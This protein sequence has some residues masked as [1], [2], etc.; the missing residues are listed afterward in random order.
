[1]IT[2]KIYN[3]M[4]L[5]VLYL[6]VSLI[7]HAQTQNI[8]GKVF[9]DTGETV[10]GATVKVEGTSTATITN[11]DGTFTLKAAIGDKLVISYVGYETKTV[12]IVDNNLLQIQIVP[13]QSLLDEVVVVGYGQQKKAS[14]V[15]A[16]SI[17]STKELKQSPTANITNALAGKLPGL[18]TVQTS[19]EP[20]A[21][22]A[23]LY[24]RGISTFSGSQNPLIL[25]DGVERDFKNMNALEIETISILKDA[26][27]TAVYGVRG[28]NGVVL[29]TTKRGQSGKPT[30]SFNTDI[31][32]QSA[33][34]L[35][36]MVNAYEIATLI[37]EGYINEGY[38]PIYSQEELDAYKYGT[39]PYNYPN[40]NWMDFMLK[41]RTPLQQYN[42]S[43]SG[44]T[45]KAKY[46]VM[47]GILNQGGLYNFEDYNKDYNT[48]VSYERYNFRT[49]A[50]FQIN[51][52]LSTKVNLSGVLGTKHQ[53]QWDAT[54]AFDRFKISN[55]HRAP[56]KN[57]DGSWSTEEKT[58][59]NP[60]AMLLD[61]GYGDS[62]ETA[63]TATIG[64][65]ATLDEYVKGLGA[66][67][68]FSFDFNNIYIQ[69]RTRSVSFWDFNPRDGSYSEIFYGSKLGY[70][71]N[72]SVYNTRYN[73]EPSITY[74]N[75]F[76]EIHE[77]TGLLLYNQ[78][79]Y[80][81]K[82][83]V[84]LERLPY[85]RMGLVGRITYGYKNKYLAEFNAGYNGSEN[86]APGKR[87]GFFP[88]GSLGWVAS[89][90]GFFKKDF[91]EYLKLRMSVGLVGNDQIGGDRYLYMSLYKDDTGAYFGYPSR[92]R[93]AGLSELRLGNPE[94]TW[95][96]ATK[97][98]LGIDTRIF[99]DKL[100]LTL[101]AFY[102]RRKDILTT[103]STIPGTFGFNNLVSNDGVVSNHGFEIDGMWRSR[104]GK[105]FYFNVGG[106]FSF[107]RNK[108]ESMP[109]SPQQYDYLLRTGTR[110]GQPFGKIGLGLF[111]SNE[112]ILK[113][114]SQPA[115]VQPGDIKYMDIN[116][117][118]VVNANDDHPIGNP[119]VPEIFFS[120]TLGFSF[121]SFDFVC[122]FQG[123]GNSTY[124]FASAQ[125]VP[126][127]NENNTPLKVWMGRWTPENRNAIY[128][129]I[130]P[131]NNE[132]NSLYSSF[133]Q[134]DNTYLRLKNM[135]LGYTFNKKFI[136]K[137]GL[138]NLRL[139]VNSVNLFTWD[140][141]KVYDPENYV[142]GNRT[143]YPVMRII[144][145]GLN[146]TF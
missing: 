70:G 11:V 112:E 53:P 10:I 135:E 6:M 79:E 99:G 9:D 121:K 13:S 37:N 81:K 117:D 43:I 33:T 26:S 71:E 38:N 45:A 49:N 106:T 63:I 132:N 48:Q 144:N 68:D 97:Y 14:V 58:S 102:E 72:L 57:P 50:D 124:Y 130:T 36:E 141:V 94:L 75:V 110:I 32:F 85:R 20:G 111:Q 2:M 59:F 87:F 105:D 31:G 83:G 120:A 142:Q 118:G 131:H 41:D 52:V 39:D 42:L 82:S 134:I 143:S 35:P 65:K 96:K 136:S 116:G 76:N 15:G 133:W 16:I 122:M 62:K 61:G 28:A 55:P 7:M 128:P 115:A 74:N 119:E 114:P 100:S 1:M 123:A 140:N 4:F 21:D 47:V 56:I 89:E 73:L 44:G 25:V 113:S 30:V 60:V 137:I 108:I 107:A 88:A 146:V 139:Y 138:E 54:Y 66:N 8:S 27:A 127:I 93:Y 104:I 77:V 40:I 69:T 18:I 92:S 103:I 19:G 95:E 125:N 91:V 126:F 109:E 29:V 12:E 80:I 46:F 78:S 34:R 101:D 22:I 145:T 51:S 3:K 86:F 17:V 24:I 67:V 84:A 90:E 129:R 5:L 23:R 64:M 98:N